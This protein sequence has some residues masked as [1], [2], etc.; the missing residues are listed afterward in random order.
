[1]TSASLGFHCC[2]NLLI[3]VVVKKAWTLL[4]LSRGCLLSHLAVCWISWLSLQY[5]LIK[6]KDLVGLDFSHLGHGSVPFAPSHLLCGPALDPGEPGTVGR[7]LSWVPAPPLV[8]PRYTTPGVLWCDLNVGS[9]GE[10]REHAAAFGL[11]LRGG[12]KCLW[13]SK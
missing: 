1:M 8:P 5:K 13:N 2:E 6:T 3:T 7:T 12:G 9:P 11:D 4:G 10:G